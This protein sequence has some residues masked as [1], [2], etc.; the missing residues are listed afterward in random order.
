M[1]HKWV[2]ARLAT[3]QSAAIAAGGCGSKAFSGGEKKHAFILSNGAV[4]GRT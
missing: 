2:I 4:Y 1:N 3:Y